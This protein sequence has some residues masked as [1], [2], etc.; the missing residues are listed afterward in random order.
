MLSQQKPV[1]WILVTDGKKAQVYVWTPKSLTL[2]PDFTVYSESPEDY[3]EKLKK[4]GTIFESGSSLRHSVQ[5]H[6]DIHDEIRLHFSTSILS[7]LN[8]CRENGNFDRLIIA[9]PD[10]LLGLLRKGLSKKTEDSLIADIPKNWTRYSQ[11]KLLL[12]IKDILEQ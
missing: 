9:A 11:E 8:K 1:T 4:P 10:K 7:Q 2:V 12:H 6:I 3:A 5:P